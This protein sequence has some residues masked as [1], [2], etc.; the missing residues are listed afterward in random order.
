[1]KF[2]F[3]WALALGLRDVKF[4]SDNNVVSNRRQGNKQVRED[5]SEIDV[6]SLVIHIRTCPPGRGSRVIG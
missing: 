2:H 6:D 1:M 3:Y 4:H 5:F